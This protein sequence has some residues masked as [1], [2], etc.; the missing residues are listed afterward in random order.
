MCFDNRTFQGASGH[1]SVLKPFHIRNGML[2][3]RLYIDLMYIMGGDVVHGCVSVVHV[4]PRTSRLD[5]L[6]AAM[7]NMATLT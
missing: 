7:P 2:W 6:S 4:R 3:S 5:R 1:R